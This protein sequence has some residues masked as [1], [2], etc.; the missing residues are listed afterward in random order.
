M[1]PLTPVWFGVTLL[2]ISSWVGAGEPPANAW[3]LSIEALGAHQ[4]SADRD[5]GGTVAMDETALRIGVSRPLTPSLRLGLNLGYAE[6]AYDFTAG[7][8]ELAAAAPWSTI[9]SARAGVS[10]NARLGDR[11]TLFALPSIRWAAEDGAALDDGAFGGVLAAAS[12]RVSDRLTIGPGFGAFSEI[13]GDASL[14]PILALD[15]RLTDTLSLNTGGG[16]AASRGPGLVLEWRPAD[17]WTL[18]LGAR[19]ENERFRLNDQGPAPNGVGQDSSIPIYL[20]VVRT[21]GRFVSLSLIA[22]AK[23]AGN[24]RLENAQGDKLA[25]TDYATAPFAGVTL[26]VRF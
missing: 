13:E 10:L 21:L 11:W 23:T 26:K 6:F 2:F 20:G 9:R 24:L 19:Y 7:A 12:Y 5:G 14:F 1:H 18:S 17:A 3:G 4:F 16:L 15:W 22:G 25:A 8:Q